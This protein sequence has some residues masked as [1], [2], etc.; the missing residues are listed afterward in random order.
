MPTGSPSES[1]TSEMTTID[2]A[3]KA[4]EAAVSG[5]VTELDWEKS[6]NLWKVTVVST[7]G[8]ENNV[9][10][11]G[12]TGKVVSGPS[13][14]SSSADEK[15]QEKDLADSAKLTYAQ[16]VEKVQEEYPGAK[17]HELKLTKSNGTPV[18]KA[19]YLTSEGT[20]G[21]VLISAEDGSVV[22]PSPSSSESP[23]ESESPMPTSTG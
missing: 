11:D 23:S 18:W 13:A 6:D 3:G 12:K 20:K 14:E 22:T 1:M 9:S 2:A 5:T 21:K 4:A 16:A 8:T 7:D 10:I 19:E 15:A 17:I